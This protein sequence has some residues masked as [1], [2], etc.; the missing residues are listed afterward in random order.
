METAPP[1]RWF[2]HVMEGARLET[3]LQIMV[4]LFIVNGDI[5]CVDTAEK[6]YP[7]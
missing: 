5:I 4:P 3:G 1:A 2:E 6:K 7:G